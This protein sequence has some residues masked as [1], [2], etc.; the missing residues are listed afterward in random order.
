MQRTT[1]LLLTIIIASLSSVTVA[2][3]SVQ[4]RVARG[5]ATVN[6]VLEGTVRKTGL[7]VAN[8]TADNPNVRWEIEAGTV[9]VRKASSLGRGVGMTGGILEVIA[10][11]A[12]PPLTL[13]AASTLQADNGATVTV[14]NLAGAFLLTTVGPGTVRFTGDLSAALSSLNITSL[15]QVGVADG[16]KLP[17]GGVT[18][19]HGAVLH[20]L[21]AVA[22][23]VPGA[24]VV[25]GTIK[26]DD[27]IAV[28]VN[29]FGSTILVNDGGT[30]EL[31]DGASWD[32]AITVGSPV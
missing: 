15:L 4:I 32:H 5:E 16:D 17:R 22:G 8:V 13:K 18:V 9:K 10:T 1:F 6:G 20:F 30:L 3:A 12:A 2:A 31:G 25:T 24:L 19:A 27:G 29:T 14:S 11:L 23:S 21:K 7:G 26:V 28:P